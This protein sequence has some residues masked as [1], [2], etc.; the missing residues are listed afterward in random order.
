[1]PRILQLALPIGLE[2]SEP[3]PKEKL[4]TA[5]LSMLECLKE[6]RP[7]D[8]NSLLSIKYATFFKKSSRDL[9]ITAF[10]AFS[11]IISFQ[12]ILSEMMTI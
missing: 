8:R 12:K 6:L 4:T 1:M 10:R 11:K 7:V 2:Y 9:K 3:I 5:I